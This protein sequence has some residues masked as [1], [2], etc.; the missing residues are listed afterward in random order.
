[1]FKEAVIQSRRDVKRRIDELENLVRDYVDCRRSK[2]P[3]I[4]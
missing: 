4:Y 3:I 1:M 2:I